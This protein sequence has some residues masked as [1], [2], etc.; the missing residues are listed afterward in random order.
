MRLSKMIAH[1]AQSE[2]LASL[3]N[4]LRVA[5]A[6]RATSTKADG[7]PEHNEHAGARNPQSH[8]VA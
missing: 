4:G 6:L 1:S 7:F 3:K 5:S 8:L 2:K